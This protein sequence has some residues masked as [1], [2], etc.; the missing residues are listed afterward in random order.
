MEAPQQQR[1][2]LTFI[3]LAAC[4]P[5]ILAQADGNPH[6]WSRERRCDMTGYDPPCGVCEGYGGIPY[7]DLPDQI[8]M[9]TCEIINNASILPTDAVRPVWNERFV[10][11]NVRAILI[12]PKRDPYCL[13]AA[14]GLSSAGPLCY[15][16]S[17]DNETYDMSHRGPRAI[18]HDSIA[19]T[20]FGPS[21]ST[22][23]MSGLD[24]WVLGQDK[25]GTDTCICTGGINKDTGL[26]L[27]PV[28]Y[29]WTQQMQYVG[30]ERL[31]V[32]API[33]KVMVLDHWVYGPH[34]AWSVPV[35]GKFIR[36]YQ[37]YNG[38]QVF[39]QGTGNS[40]HM[41]DPSLLAT[42]PPMCKAGSGAVR[43][44]CDDNGEPLPK[45][46][47][48][49]ASVLGTTLHGMAKDR[50]TDMQRALQ[51]VPRPAF[52]GAGFWNMSSILNNWLRLRV[53]AWKECDGF[54]AQEL[55][56]LQAV[57]YE[58]RDPQLNKV[59][60][61]ATDPMGRGG[62]DRRQLGEDLKQI[63]REWELLNAA[64]Q[65]HPDREVL[66]RMQ[67]DGHCHEAVMIFVHHL[68]EDVKAVLAESG[69]EIPLLS[70]QPHHQTCKQGQWQPEGSAHRQVCQYYQKAVSC[71]DCHSDV[72]PPV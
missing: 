13:T 37:P 36:T 32:E 9:T 59:Y 2:C 15:S 24:F 47:P 63:Q 1:L 19:E 65:G 20:P 28:Q 51:Q 40:S 70:F 34:H 7:G 45:L 25:N 4:L 53:A 60:S 61:Q 42:P 21:K 44:G 38:F 18:R 30:R 46:K 35:T 3:F 43:T 31:G 57:M 27:Y 54:T 58:A 8:N 16:P 48:P 33:N 41:P 72:V 64:V 66:Q 23:L 11:N 14:P 68:S 12:G 62:A 5:C 71:V 10:S 39:P 55:Q 17:V 69:V 56:E 49:S 6:G 52:K 67:R 22:I 29:N 26:A 50:Q